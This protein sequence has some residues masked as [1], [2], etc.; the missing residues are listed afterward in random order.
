MRISDRY[1]R[2][3]DRVGSPTAKKTNEKS[4]AEGASG[5]SNSDALKVEVS[6]TAKALAAGTAKLDELKASVQNGTYK[7]DSRAIARKLVGE[8]E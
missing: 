5:A 1:E 8:D 3:L 4:G 6:A 2:F 7:V